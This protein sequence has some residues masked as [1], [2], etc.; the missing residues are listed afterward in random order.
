MIVP[1]SNQLYFQMTLNWE[2]LERLPFKDVIHCQE[3]PFQT[4]SLQLEQLLLHAIYWPIVSSGNWKWCFLRLYITSIH[5]L[6]KLSHYNRRCMVECSAHFTEL[7]CSK[8]NSVKFAEHSTIQTFYMC[9]FYK[10]ASLQFINIP[11]TGMILS[12]YVRS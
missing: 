7:G 9:T 5:N 12:S 8:L 10:C 4:A 11:T 3:S 1:T 2:K 6:S